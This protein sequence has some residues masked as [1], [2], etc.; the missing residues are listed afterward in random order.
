MLALLAKPLVGLGQQQPASRF[1]SLVTAAQQAQ[2]AH[3]YAAAVTEY[4]QAVRIEPKM[5]ELWAN[6]GLMQQQAG[7]I[8]AAILSFHQSNILNPNLYVPNLFLG[9]D[10]VRTG[11]A[12]RAIPF[13]TKAQRINKSDPQTPLALGRAYFVTGMFLPAIREF[14]RATTL[15]PKLDAAWFALGIARLNQVEADAHQMSTENKSSAFAGALLAG[16]LEKQGRFSEAA[17]LYR[18]L[19]DLKPQPPCLHSELGFALLRHHDTDGAGTEFAGER[20]A[21]PECGLA[22]L[23]HARIAIEK[24]DNEQAIK[25]LNEL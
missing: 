7:D 1:E 11:K 6:L 13:L 3:D 5:P 17:S 19:F 20:A 8:P 4:K 9:V 22:L 14:E 25:L 23:G 12:P 15:D 10:F 2:A 18:T 21:H 24:G 16:S